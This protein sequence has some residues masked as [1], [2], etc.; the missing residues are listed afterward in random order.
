MTAAKCLVAHDV[1]RIAVEAIC[2][3]RTVERFLRGEEIKDGSE[4]RIRAAMVRCGL[5]DQI[6][7]G[8]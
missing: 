7:K 8:R 6:P 2:D 4:I 3:P 1:R 5:E